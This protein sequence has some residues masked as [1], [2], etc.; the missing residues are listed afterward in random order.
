MIA[1]DNERTLHEDI[2]DLFED[3]TPDRRSWKQAETGTKGMS[4]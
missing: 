2:A 3:R 4:G 1:K